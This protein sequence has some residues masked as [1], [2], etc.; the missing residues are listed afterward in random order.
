MVAAALGS[1]GRVSGRKLFA[2]VLA[3]VAVGGG[4]MAGWLDGVPVALLLAAIVGAAVVSEVVAVTLPAGGSRT[5]LHLRI[6]A[7]VA[8]VSVAVYVTGWG[9]VLA[10]GYLYIVVDAFR[11]HG[12]RAQ[13]PLLVW[14][15][16]E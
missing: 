10:A 4:R 11:K 3:I 14:V 5:A 7:Q 9:A 13:A 16:A 1:R 6:A 8:G 15:S 12:S 2:P